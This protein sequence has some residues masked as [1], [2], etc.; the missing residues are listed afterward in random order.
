MPQSGEEKTIGS[1]K[2]LREI[3]RGGMATV[4]EVED[5]EG[6]K[7]ALKVLDA[8]R[9]RNERSLG[10]FLREGEAIQRLNHP[11]IIKIIDVGQEGDL[12]FIAMELVDGPTLEDLIFELRRGRSPG[13]S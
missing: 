5:R 11:H 6:Q 1:F 7:L 9:S 10:R 4:Y 8:T 3:G 12:S 2:I 13:G